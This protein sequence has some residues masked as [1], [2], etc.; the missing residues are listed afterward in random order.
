MQLVEGLTFRALIKGDEYEMLELE[1][2]M[3]R[4]L[5]DP[6][7]YYPSDIEEFREV[8]EEGSGCG[9]FDDGRL[10]GLAVCS[11]G[12]VR[13]ELSYAR[14]IGHDPENT[15]DFR[16]VIISPAYR[17]RG[18]H[19]AFLRF[20]T[21]KAREAGARAMYCTIDP[22]NTPSVA[23]FTRAGF[24]LVKVQPAYDGRLRGYYVKPL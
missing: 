21:D 11:N 20:F 9:F 10:I 6:A 24:A 16:D 4:A 23:G 22:N 17:L 14:K 7:W 5:P 8:C 1:E 3:L 13:G 12:D 19:R 15:W 2:E 18:L